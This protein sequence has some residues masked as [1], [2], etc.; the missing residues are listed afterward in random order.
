MR[1]TITKKS[2]EE[3]VG[4]VLIVVLVTIIALVFLAINLRKTPEKL[5]SLELSSFLQSAM[6][7]STDCYSSAELRENVKDLIKSCYDNDA[8]IDGRMTCDVLNET[9]YD[10]IKEGF[11]PG[12]KNPVKSSGLKIYD[13]R[14]NKTIL[15]I[16]QG[17]CLGTKSGS[18]VLIPSNIKVEIEICS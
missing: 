2:Q 16:K 8:C 6:K 4:F 11:K 7:Y 5:E 14:T 9:L 3:M 10:I 17:I 18:S 15:N 12:E 1:V 13:S